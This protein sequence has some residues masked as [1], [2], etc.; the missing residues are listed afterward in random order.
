M[1]RVKICGITNM[2]DAEAVAAAGGDAIGLNFYAQSPRF[3]ALDVAAEIAAGMAGQLCR[4]GLFVN[5][6]ASEVCRTFDELRLDLIQLHGDEPPEYMAE[7]GGR[8]VMKA[9]RVSGSE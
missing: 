4:V 1:F 2:D 3:V 9:F 6:P 8:P 7:L 5:T